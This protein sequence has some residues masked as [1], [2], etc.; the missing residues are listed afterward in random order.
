[1][2]NIKQ[3]QD[4]QGSGIYSSVK[5][6]TIQTPASL[7]FKK[8]TQPKWNKMCE[9]IPHGNKG[10]LADY[11]K[12]KKELGLL[13]FNKFLEMSKG[14]I[15]EET[16]SQ[17][18]WH[19]YLID[20]KK[21]N[22]TTIGELIDSFIQAGLIVK[23]YQAEKK[24]KNKDFNR[25]IG[26][27]NLPQWIDETIIAQKRIDDRVASF[28]EELRQLNI[29][30]DKPISCQCCNKTYKARHFG[31][32]QIP[33]CQKCWSNEYQLALKASKEYGRV[34]TMKENTEH[35]LIDNTIMKNKNME[36]EIPT[37][38]YDEKDL[39]L[40]SN[41]INKYNDVFYCNRIRELGL[42]PQAEKKCSSCNQ[43][44]PHYLYSITNNKTLNTKCRI[45]YALEAVEDTNPPKDDEATILAKQFMASRKETRTQASIR[46]IGEKVK[47]QGID[48]RKQWD[49]DHPDEETFDEMLAR[50]T[51][52]YAK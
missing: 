12:R 37:M 20:K 33:V 38:D 49:I 39:E 48:W 28:D 21:N 4:L 3:F 34:K 27:P 25:Y 31:R 42:D 1:M 50:M 7:S 41:V 19:E 6:P 18:Y 45:C 24:D 40:I 52:K 44:F 23:T 35:D 2:F 36:E 22:Y 26:G 10:T 15:N 13:M 29:D 32:K 9:V 46:R 8:I 51:K 16:I 5:V 14:G 47:E 17:P 11:G 43:A 30:P